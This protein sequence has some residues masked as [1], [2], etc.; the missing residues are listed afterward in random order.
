MSQSFFRL[1]TVR[2]PT[3]Y[4]LGDARCAVAG[5]IEVSVYLP[6][7]TLLANYSIPVKITAVR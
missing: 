6:A 4:M 7:V 3:G 1:S 5:Q 2:M